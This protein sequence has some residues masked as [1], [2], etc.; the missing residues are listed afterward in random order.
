MLSRHAICVVSHVFIMYS[1]SNNSG[2]I[3]LLIS[4]YLILIVAF[5]SFLIIKNGNTKDGVYLTQQQYDALLNLHNKALKE[6][7]VKPQSTAYVKPIAIVK[8]KEIFVHYYPNANFENTDFQMSIN[9]ASNITGINPSVIINMIQQ[10]SRG[11]PSIISPGGAV[12]LMQL[13]P[14]TAGKLAYHLY[15]GRNKIPS[16][17]DLQDPNLNVILGTTYLKYLMRQFP[18]FKPKARLIL[19]VASYNWGIGNVKY[20]T[21]HYALN[22]MKQLISA[23]KYNAPYITQRYLGNVF[24]IQ[25]LSA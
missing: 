19:A 9:K 7:K 12:G 3:Y 11:N 25:T 4:L 21:A 13:Q 2:V 16:V 15:T 6:S 18:N 23:I 8:P 1:K 24:H 17:K 20:I 22:S 5:L 10:E 14:W